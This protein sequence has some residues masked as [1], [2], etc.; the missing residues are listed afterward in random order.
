MGELRNR[1]ASLKRPI[2]KFLIL[3]GPIV[4]L[5]A[6]GTAILART[7]EMIEL[8]LHKNLPKP[9]ETVLHESNPILTTLLLAEILTV[10]ILERSELEEVETIASTLSK[11]PNTEKLIHLLDLK[12][13]QLIE[14]LREPS[15]V[16]VYKTPEEVYGNVPKIVG[17]IDSKIFT[18][19]RMMHG[20][21]HLSSK[22]SAL[23]PIPSSA[24]SEV[25]SVFDST[26]GRCIQSSGPTRWVVQQIYNITT[27]E[28]LDTIIERAGKGTDGLEVRAVSIPEM[29]PCFS[30]LIVGEEDALLA[31]ADLSDFRV[32]SAIHLHGKDAIKFVEGYFDL[33]W[34]Y[35][36]SFRIRTRQGINV[37][38]VDALRKLIES[39]DK[40]AISRKTRA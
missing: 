13:Q 30:P 21:L 17:V 12:Q 14:T 27:L 34:D 2:R 7:V 33:L 9:W 15:S 20:L 37:A 4:G 3:Q 8:F 36:P 32:G 22:T 6:A 25:L 5:V 23:S 39:R 28:R 24:L 38:A 11:I 18:E 16:R 31:I 29:I 35:E 40:K 26:I 1:L 19:K 10:L